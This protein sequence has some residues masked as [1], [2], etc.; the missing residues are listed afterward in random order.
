MTERWDRWR[1]LRRWAGEL[2]GEV[3]AIALA[4]RDPRTPWFVR[5]LGAVVVAYAASPIDLIPDF[6]PVLGWLDDIVL[7]PVGIW[8]VV[9]LLPQDVL[10]E[11]RERRGAQGDPSPSRLGQ[12]LVVATWLLVLSAGVVVVC[13]QASH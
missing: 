8:L 4:V 13:R 7:L 5:L 11:A 1:A 12:A 3:S 10:T 2:V 6:I 9:A